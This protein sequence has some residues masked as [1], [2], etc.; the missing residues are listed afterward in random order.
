[1][2]QVNKTSSWFVEWDDGANREC[3]D[4]TRRVARKKTE[5]DKERREQLRR[6]LQKLRLSRQRIHQRENSA[7]EKT[8]Q[9]FELAYKRGGLWIS[10]GKIEDETRKLSMT[11]AKSILKAQI[12][13]WTKVLKCA[14]DQISFTHAT[15]N[16]LKEHLGKLTG[17][18]IPLESE[19]LSDII[20]DPESLT[21]MYI[22]HQWA[23]ETHQ[24]D[25]YYGQI[26]KF[27]NETSEYKVTYER[28]E[29]PC[30]M[31]P[32]EIITDIIRGDL[33]LQQL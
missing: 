32:G 17:T 26:V 4:H 22:A 12:N 8:E 29:T 15:V 33:V 7:R 13:I 3:T 14:G 5:A 18:N 23:D 27:M 1:M 10:P 20:R 16:Q 31:K 19:D 21:G 2:F 28:E 9:W 25:W 30:Y 24:R 11:S 6:E